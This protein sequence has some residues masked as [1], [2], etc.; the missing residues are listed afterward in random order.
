M[1]D[2][3]AIAGALARYPDLEHA[4]DGTWLWLMD[5]LLLGRA[6]GRITPSPRLHRQEELAAVRQVHVRGGARSLNDR[7]SSVPGQGRR[8][9][10]TVTA[11][12]AY[13]TFGRG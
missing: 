5:P 6:L 4:G 9:R 1:R 13:P 10:G 7:L 2:R 8:A 12:M 3:T 11:L